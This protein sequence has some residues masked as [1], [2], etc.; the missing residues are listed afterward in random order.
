MYA[1][2]Q[3][4][5]VELNTLTGYALE[6]APKESSFVGF[7]LEYGRSD[8]NS[9]SGPAGTQTEMITLFT[10]AKGMPSGEENGCEG[11]LGKECVDAMKSSI[12]SFYLNPSGTDAIPLGSNS[13]I[14][15]LVQTPTLWQGISACPQDILAERIC[16]NDRRGTFSVSDISTYCELALR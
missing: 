7:W 10:T 16:L 3:V 14:D 15:G 11:V 2:D 1:I 5:A 9:T 13:D 6:N 12:R 4:Q 8:L